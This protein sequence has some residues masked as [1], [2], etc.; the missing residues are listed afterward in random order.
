MLP[1][2]QWVFCD[3]INQY[4]VSSDGFF[5]VVVGFLFGPVDLFADFFEVVV[6][7]L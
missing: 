1:R 4:K 6:G 5:V 3:D 7:F 2:S